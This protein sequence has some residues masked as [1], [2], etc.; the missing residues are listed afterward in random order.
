[1][2]DRGDSFVIC[3][4]VDHDRLLGFGFSGQRVYAKKADDQRHDCKCGAPYKDAGLF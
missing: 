2:F 4:G 1:M 3:I